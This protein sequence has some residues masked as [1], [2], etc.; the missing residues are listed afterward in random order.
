MS[1]NAEILRMGRDWPL[2]P[3]ILELASFNT[4]L[5]L[6]DLAQVATEIR[7]ETA[8]TL[9]AKHHMEPCPSGLNLRACFAG[10]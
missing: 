7:A 8:T 4:R 9:G 6:A 2:N 3:T 5:N 1:I 10:V